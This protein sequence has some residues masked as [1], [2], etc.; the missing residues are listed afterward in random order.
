MPSFIF[1]VSAFLLFIL[2]CY[3]LSQKRSHI[4]WFSVF[5]CFAVM[6]G[7]SIFICY[8]PHVERIFEHLGNGIGVLQSATNSGTK[9]VFGYLGGADTPFDIPNDRKNFTHIFAFQSLPMVIVVSALSMLFFYWGVISLFVKILSP[10]FE[11]AL[12][13]GGAMGIVSITKI[14]FG[15]MEVALFVNPYLKN[16]SRS[17][18]FTLMTLGLSTSAMTII[19]VYGQIIQHLVPNAMSIFLIT[20]VITIPLVIGL[21][22]IVE[23]DRHQT[24]GSLG[25]MYNFTSS[26]DAISRG[27]REGLSIFVNIL[28]MLI[29]MAALIALCNEVLGLI[30][31]E[32]TMTLQ[33]VL[34]YV[35]SPVTLL[36]GIPANEAFQAAKILGTK[37][38]LNEV[39]AFIDFATVGPSLSLKTQIILTS[40]LASFA[41][42]GSIGV[43]VAGIAAMCPE[44]RNNLISFGYKTL[45]IGILATCLTASLLGILLVR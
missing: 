42:F 32:K 8:I 37:V 1:P 41:N 3:Y 20:N 44:Q 35:F 16:F 27:T 39:F 15:P 29:V 45:L 10:I 28:A 43:T 6:F 4:D 34:G 40:A 33:Y 26:L 13:I 11:R 5:K 7:L 24:S 30:P 17:E 23:P 31:T 25:T 2:L 12:S 19:P 21:C 9:F 36:M 18:I 22:K 14:F 38:A